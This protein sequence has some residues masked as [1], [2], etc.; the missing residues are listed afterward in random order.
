MDQLATEMGFEYELTDTSEQIYIESR[1]VNMTTNCYKIGFIGFCIF[2]HYGSF[3][4]F[5]LY[6]ERK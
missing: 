2:R 4:F 6:R 1:L 3:K 5:I